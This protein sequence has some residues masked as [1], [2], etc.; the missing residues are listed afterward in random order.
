MSDSKGQQQQQDLVD[1]SWEEIDEDRV[2][3]RGRNDD[4]SEGTRKCTIWVTIREQ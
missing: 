3:V 1:D 4:E 2:S